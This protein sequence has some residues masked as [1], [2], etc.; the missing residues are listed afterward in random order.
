MMRIRIW[1][2]I[3][4]M[5]GSGARRRCESFI[6]GDEEAD[7][8]CHTTHGTT[9]KSLGE[10]DMHSVADA[11]AILIKTNA[12]ANKRQAGAKKRDET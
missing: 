3:E 11:S 5:G 4:K 6:A 1:R 7:I 9:I 2:C 8:E 12:W 10:A